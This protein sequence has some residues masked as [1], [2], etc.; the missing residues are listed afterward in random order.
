[1]ATSLKLSEKEG[2]IDHLQFNTYH[3]VQRLRKLVSRSWDK[4]TVI[5]GFSGP[6][7]AIFLPNESVLGAYDGSGPLFLILQGTWPWQPILWEN[8]KLPTFVALAFK[9]GMWYCYRNVHFNS[10]NDVEKFVNFGLVTP[11]LIQLICKRLIRHGQ[12]LTYLVAYVRIHWTDFY[13]FFTIWK[14]F[15][16]RWWIYALFFDLSRDVGTTTCLGAT[17]QRQGGY[18]LG[19]AMHF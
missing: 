4:K 18:T 17:L 16:W 8:G 7:F 15:G 9:N 11:D 1:M 5:S 12:K 13:I 14:D 6:I 19:F 10:V 3:M 2:R